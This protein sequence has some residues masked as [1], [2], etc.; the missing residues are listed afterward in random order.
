M[1]EGAHTT[2]EAR[3]SVHDAH[4]DDPRV[5]DDDV[6]LRH[7]ALTSDEEDLLADVVVH[8]LRHEARSN[9]DEEVVTIAEEVGVE[10]LRGCRP[11]AS[12]LKTCSL[13]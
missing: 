4:E 5:D 13:P 8:A 1:H 9:G 11:S 6:E 7:E 3:Y 10:G 2:Y 12:L